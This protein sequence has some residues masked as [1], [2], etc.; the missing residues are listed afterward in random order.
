[1]EKG[2]AGEAIDPFYE[3]MVFE[4]NNEG[5]GGGDMT[6]QD[7]RVVYRRRVLVL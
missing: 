2:R 6:S 7:R 5:D 3:D 1:M 4:L